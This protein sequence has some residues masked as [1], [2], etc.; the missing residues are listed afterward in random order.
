[1]RILLQSKPLSSKKFKGQSDLLATLSQPITIDAIGN[2][3]HRPLLFLSKT[4]MRKLGAKVT[5]VSE[6]E[7]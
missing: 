5:N 1:L 6:R 4:S 7:L 3:M 2:Y